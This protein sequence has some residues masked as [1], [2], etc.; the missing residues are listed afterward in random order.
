LGGEQIDS[1][2][3]IT[4]QDF[5][6]NEGDCYVRKFCTQRTSACMQWCCLILPLWWI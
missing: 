4:M 6:G 5:D 2:Q 3:V 1:T